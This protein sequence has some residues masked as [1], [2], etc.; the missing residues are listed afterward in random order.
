MR[1]KLVLLGLAVAAGLTLLAGGVALVARPY[2][3]HGSVINPPIPAEDF[4]LTDQ[5]GQPFRLSDQIGSVVLLFFGYTSCP[6]VCPTTLAK[7]K[8][9][10][11][12]LGDQADRVRFVLVTVDPERDTAERLRNYL[13]AF[14]SSFVGLTGTTAELEAVWQKYGVYREKV[15]GASATGY[16][17]DHSTSTYLVDAQGRL[18]LTHPYG[19]TADDLSQDVRYLVKEAGR[20]PAGKTNDRPPRPAKVPATVTTLGDLR[21]QE[22]WVR[23]GGEGNVTAAFL[24]IANASDQPDALLAVQSEI[25]ETI[26]I[27]VSQMEDGVMRMRP[28]SRLEIPAGGQVEVV[29]SGGHHLML[30]G[31]TRTIAVGERVPLT[32]HFERGGEVVV[33]AEVISQ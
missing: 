5:H 3:F 22:V 2:T 19:L 9:V 7:F 6:D 27:H 18:R 32:L 14:N 13:G 29:P 30:I 15:G 4:V 11:T 24:T 10:H 33:E 21:I 26:E 8:Q 1:S 25:A 20:A 17:V 23:P 31:L 16:V 12:Q 28:V